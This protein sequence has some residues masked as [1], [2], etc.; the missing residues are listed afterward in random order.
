M[1]MTKIQEAGRSRPA[2]LYVLDL[3]TAIIYNEVESHFDFGVWQGWHNM[4]LG[5]GLVQWTKASKILTEMGTPDQDDVDKFAESDPKGLMDLQLEF[6]IYTS[7]SSTHYSEKEWHEY[8]SNKK[9]NGFG[10]REIV[11]SLLPF[12][13]Y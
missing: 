11:V 12:V 2:F 13:R 4:E 8:F 1:S 5:Y 3:E 10:R 6:L 9:F 7:Q